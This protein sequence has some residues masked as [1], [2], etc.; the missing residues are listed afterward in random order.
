MSD[1]HIA[2]VKAFDALVRRIGIEE[3]LGRA[4]EEMMSESNPLD[5]QDLGDKVW[6]VAKELKEFKKRGEDYDDKHVSVPV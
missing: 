4:A 5:V 2:E 3:I 6:A 1:E